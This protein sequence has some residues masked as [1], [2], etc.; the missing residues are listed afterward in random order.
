MNIGSKFKI[1][2]KVK[3]KDINDFSLSSTIFKSKRIRI[4][5]LPDYGIIKTIGGLDSHL[6]SF[7]FYMIEWSNDII[8]HNSEKYLVKVNKR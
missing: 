5:T 1:G 4:I 6:G 7:R 8:T 3:F 2:D